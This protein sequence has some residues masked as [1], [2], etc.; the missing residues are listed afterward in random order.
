MAPFKRVAGCFLTDLGE[1]LFVLLM[2][3][4]DLSFMGC[5]SFF[6]FGDDTKGGVSESN[7]FLEGACLTGCF[8]T[9]GDGDAALTLKLFTE[10]GFFLEAGDAVEMFLLL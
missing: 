5:H 2:G 6:D 9:P 4:A 1:P 10:A 8:L 3:D 7:D